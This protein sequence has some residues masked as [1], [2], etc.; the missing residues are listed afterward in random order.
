VRETL[1]PWRYT[2]VDQRDLV[3]QPDLVAQRI[4]SLLGLDDEARA[5][6]AGTFRRT[7]AQQTAPGTTERLAPLAEIGWTQAEIEEFVATC[8]PEMTAY[9]Y[10]LDAGYIVTASET[11]TD[12]QV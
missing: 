8:G 10:S 2:E 3:V 9:G 1:E 5:R 4:A 6:I 12:L 11:I 7:R